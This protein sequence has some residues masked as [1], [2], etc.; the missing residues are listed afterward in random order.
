MAGGNDYIAKIIAA[1]K[2][3]VDNSKTMEEVHENIKNALRLLPEQIP[4]RVMWK[5][6]GKGPISSYKT[7][8]RQHYLHVEIHKRDVNS[9]DKSKQC[10]PCICRDKGQASN[11]HRDWESLG[12]RMEY[13]FMH[14]CTAEDS[15]VMHTIELENITP[16]DTQAL[17]GM[18]D[19]VVVVGCIL[20]E[21]R[22]ILKVTKGGYSRRGGSPIPSHTVRSIS[23]ASLPALEDTPLFRT[24]LMGS[25][26]ALEALSKAESRHTQLLRCVVTGAAVLPWERKIIAK[27]L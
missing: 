26:G 7:A 8:L 9:N 10:P 12:A 18:K 22:E 17:I 20:E 1:T 25:A 5:G 15:S 2:S 13:G 21:L 4:G 27:K 19:L 24:M 14:Q 6:L 3:V 23:I 11:V 16:Q